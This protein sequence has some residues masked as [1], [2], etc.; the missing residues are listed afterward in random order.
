MSKQIA[1]E[2][3]TRADQLEEGIKWL[4]AKLAKEGKT[5]EVDMAELD[6][7]TGVGVVVTEE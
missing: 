3:W 4:D 5:Y 6:L 2:K 7:E 1:E